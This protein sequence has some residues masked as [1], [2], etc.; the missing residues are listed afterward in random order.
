[1]E[2]SKALPIEGIEDVEYFDRGPAGDQWL[3]RFPNG[4][5]AS[6]IRG[7]YTYGGPEGFYEVGVIT[8]DPRERSEIRLTYDTPLTND[9][10]G[11]QSLDEVADV[12]LR[13]SRLP[14]RV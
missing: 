9:V 8:Y 11:W 5:G 14:A 6:V 7:A 4:Y 12:L 1:M 10:L 13:I 2:T 3:A